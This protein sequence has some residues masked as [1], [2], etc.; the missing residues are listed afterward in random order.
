MTRRDRSGSEDHEPQGAAKTRNADPSSQ[1]TPRSSYGASNAAPSAAEPGAP[2]SLLPALSAP[3]GGGAIRG[4]GEKFAVSAATGTA[5]LG[6]PLPVSPGRGGFG[7]ELGLS[8]DGGNGNGPFGLGFH[9]SVPTITRKT[10]K[11][12]P[13][14][15]DD[16]ESD[17]YVLSGAEDL[18]PLRDEVSGKPLEFERGD[19][20]ARRY[21]PRIEGLFARIE[22]W[23]HKSTAAIHWRVTTKDNTTHIYGLSDAAELPDRSV[24]A[25]RI[26]DP[27]D[28]RRVFSW[29]L[30]ESRDDRGNVV[31]YEYKAEDGAGVDPGQLRERSRFESRGATRRFLASAQRYLKRVLYSNAQPA[32]ASDFLFELV[33]DYG[34]HAPQPTPSETQAWPVRLDAFSSYRAGFEVRSYRLC[35]RVLMFHRLSADRAPLLVKSTDLEYEPGGAFTYLIGITQLGYLFE[36]TSNSWQKQALPTLRLDFTRFALNDE[37]R[38]LPQESRDGLAG[39]VD[40]RSKQWVDLDGEGIPGV[41]IDAEG[42]WYYKSNRGQGTLA[43]PR[44]LAPVPAPSSLTSGVQKLEDLG[45][46]GQL[47]LVS[48]EPPLTGYFSRNAEGG[49]EPLRPFRALPNIDWN[50]PNLRFI[51]LD[52]DGHADLLIT[53][54]DAFIWYR[55]RVKDG[56]EP[57]QRLPAAFDEDLGA[58]V[59]FADSEQRIQLADM[60][61]DG[62]IDIVRLRN[63]EVCYWPNLGYGRF[64]AKVT[65]ENS[66]VFAVADEFDARRLRFADVDGSGTADLLYLGARQITLYLNQSGNALSAAV[67]IRALPPSDSM[68]QVSVV[69]LLGQGTACLVWTS[70]G[71]SSESRPVLFVDL[72][73][74]VKPHLLRRVSNN[75]GAETL[76]T[77]APSTKFYLADQ[78]AGTPWLTRLPF[79]VHVV[80]RVDRYD[81]ISSSHLTTTYSYHH[82]FFDGFEREFRGF[83]RVEQ[84]DAEEF[85]VGSAD[86]TL[87]QAP[88]RTVTWFHTGAW[89]EKE[90]LEVALAKEY[91]PKT[92]AQLVLPDTVLPL[93][94]STQDQ[95]EAARALRGHQLRQEVYAEDG[96]DQAA[97]PYSVTESNFEVRRLQPSRGELRYGVFFTHPR[98]SVTAH[99][100]RNPSDPRVTHEL[101]LD[102]DDF[103]NVTRKA[104]ISYA[105]AGAPALTPEQGKAWATLAETDYINHAG[106]DFHRVGVTFAERSFELTGLTLPFAGQGLMQ[107]PALKALVN[108]LDPAKDVAYDASPSGIGVE[109]RLLDSKQQLF[110]RDDQSAA[111][112]LGQIESLA[113]P[114]A[115]Y[116][117]ALTPG[118]VAEIAAESQALTGVA[119][120]PSILL[121]E[122]H[123]VQRDAGYWTASGQLRFDAARF[124]LPTEA[125]DPFGQ[126]H[127]VSYDEFSLLVVATKDPLGNVT[128]AVNDYRVLA[129][130]ELTDANLNRI[131]VA[132]DALGMVIAT[133]VMGKAAG[134]VEG[135]TLANPTTRLVYDILRFQSSGLPAFVH[136]ISREVHFA[137]SATTRFQESYAYSDGFGRIAMQK[138]QAEPGPVPGVTGTVSPR[139]V[140]TGRTVFNNKGNPVKQYEPF[141]SAT[142][143]FEDE[144]SIVATGVTPIIHYDPLDRVIRTELP[145]GSET[146]VVFDVWQQRSFDQNDA[147]VGTRWL[148]EHQAGTPEERR[149]AALALEHADT[150][151]ITH[152]D[153]LGRAFLVQTDNGPDPAN[154]GGPHRLYD[155]R[156]KL[157]VEGNALALIDARQALASQNSSQTP[158]PPPVPTVVQRF[159]VRARRQR[160]ES[161]DAGLRLMLVDVTGKPLRRWDGRGQILRYRYDELQRQTHVFVRQTVAERAGQDLSERLLVRTLYGEALDPLAPPGPPSPPPAAGSPPPAPSTAQQANLRGQL[162]RLYD[163]AGLA[164]SVRFDFKGNLLESERR[165]AADFTTEPNWIAFPDPSGPVEPATIAAIQAAAE[166]KLDAISTAPLT[167]FTTQTSYDALNRVTSRSTPDGSVSAPRYNAAGLLE[168]VEVSVRGAPAQTVVANIDYNARGQRTVYEYANP[169]TSPITAAQPTVTCRVDYSYDPF[170][171][172][173]TNLSTRRLAPAA[174]LQNLNYF[175]DPVGNIVELQD[176]ADSEP[177]FTVR[178]PLGDG[179]GQYTYDPLYRLLT[180]TGREHPA[181]EATADDAQLGLTI[182]HPNDLQALQR[183]D[184]VYA[185]DEV[186]NIQSIVHHVGGAGWTRNYAYKSDSNR[187]DATSI[188]GSPLNL[189]ARY[190]YDPHGSMTSMPHLA[191]MDWDYADRLQHTTKLASATDTQET[192]FA[193]D[194]AGERVRKVFVHSGLVEERIYLGGWEI[195][196]KRANT[197]GASLDLERETLHVMDDARRVAMIETK[198]TDS[199][200]GATG[201]GVARWRFQLDNHM[202]SGRFEL[203][204]AGKIISYEEYHPFGSTAFHVADGTAE[205]SAKRYRYIG[206]E[207][208]EETGLYYLG[209][210]YYAAWLGRWTAADPGGTRDSTN[211]FV[212]ARNA[213]LV[214]F[215]PNGYQSVSTDKEQLAQASLPEEH[216]RSTDPSAPTAREEAAQSSISE[217]H[218]T[219]PEPQIH[220]DNFKVGSTGVRLR[221]DVPRKKYDTVV[222]EEEAA[223]GRYK[224]AEIANNPGLGCSFC[225]IVKEYATRDEAEAA[226]DLKHFNQVA[227]GLRVARDLTEFVATGVIFKSASLA[228]GGASPGANATGSGSTRSFFTVQSTED[229]ARLQAGGAPWP[230]APTR[231]HLGEGAYSFESRS[232]AEQYQ[233]KLAPHVPSDVKLHV[234]EL[235]IEEQALA[236]LKRIDLRGNDALAESFVARH[237][238]LYGAGEPHLFEYVIRPTNVAPEHFFSPA[239]FPLFRVSY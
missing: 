30:E 200:T 164:T 12:L 86:S 212:Y 134:P 108:S 58:H 47:D 91:F 196:R 149:A 80:E 52:G 218:P 120:D 45:G 113:L 16:Q 122:G 125:I 116:Q 142:S 110:Y 205:V 193:Y 25:P 236:G 169:T 18:V 14:Y 133:A 121:N 42:A 181:Q 43:P 127:F 206:K 189:T 105:R 13:R 75:L 214:L 51:D 87:F 126:H 174:L 141:F 170:T 89:L 109:R 73:G 2:Q 203:D 90:R 225:H 104:A 59:V 184:E 231:A 72:L 38:A 129:P 132:F 9:L 153:T 88:V 27:N 163:C 235:E 167:V 7:P 180:A 227:V 165:L 171:F 177:I 96:T 156:T 217:E 154:P 139:W 173:L 37:L 234:V 166:P 182:P 230:T 221:A 199:A 50:D 100:E 179:D 78:A 54:N 162:Y 106:D 98:E 219:P 57:A 99:T 69:D 187:L 111:L 213:P 44:L 24:A 210:R 28:P 19:Y 71:P 22:R 138:V 190:S 94:M 118:L 63:G 157:G 115:S 128:R 119:F 155:T 158:K 29:L 233:A 229:A 192:F 34:E 85:T 220:P 8:Y 56:F 198:T 161:K 216:L 137:D 143:D 66:P 144:A 6:V 232:A 151:T 208:D 84:T 101:L 48:Y 197:P 222:A 26:A 4:L 65:L 20:L 223:H 36:P 74:G 82:G 21:R 239:A 83:A 185:Y 194:A 107:L 81:S 77:H 79:P 188:P 183:Y 131:Q 152:Q 195:Y 148:T 64:G 150:P 3:K 168:R 67:P 211:L 178:P 186:G 10:D 92:G 60:T 228:P 140:G 103:G 53:E 124:Y 175:Y 41:L 95:R 39:G 123:Y 5:S 1:A 160:T 117:L 147:V 159:D 204:D 11:G 176:R 70:P 201:V 40:G 135:D 17:V 215:D 31:R 93:G 102:V 130:S 202:G 112:A 55:S 76:L 224:L 23:T 61:G 33:F 62:L 237:S 146:R 207:R 49:F 238:K 136:S 35:Q 114:F 46:D 226:L 68:S 97:L 32:Q 15:W 191:V 209:A 172:R 145:D